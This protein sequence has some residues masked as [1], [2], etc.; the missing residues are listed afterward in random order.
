MADIIEPTMRVIQIYARNACKAADH[1]VPA[2]MSHLF[3]LMNSLVNVRGHKTVVRFLPHEAADMEP[4]V[5]L[6]W[7]QS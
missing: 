5:E 7:F 6:L 1:K 2:E 3:E 4:C